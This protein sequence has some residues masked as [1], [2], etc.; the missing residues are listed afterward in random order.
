MTKAAVLVDDKRHFALYL[1]FKRQLFARHADFFRTVEKLVTDHAYILI[2]AQGYPL[3]VFEIPPPGV[4]VYSFFQKAITNGWA[5]RKIRET[6]LV[7]MMNS[8]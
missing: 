5:S 3:M 6:G 7:R 1:I 2:L 8:S 4:I